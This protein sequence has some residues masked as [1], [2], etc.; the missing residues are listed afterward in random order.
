MQKDL[1]K[2]YIFDI[3][4]T[5]QLTKSPTYEDI[6]TAPMNQIAVELLRAAYRNRRFIII[7]SAR[8]GKYKEQ[9][10][11]WL[12]ENRIPFDDLYMRED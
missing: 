7:I 5:L 3:D 4:Q 12:E 1:P 10:V 8:P 6:D 2:A 9:T 11:K